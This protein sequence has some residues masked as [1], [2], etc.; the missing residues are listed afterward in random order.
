MTRHVVQSGWRRGRIES[1][2]RARLGLGALAL[3]EATVSAVERVVLESE[4][5][6]V[7]AWLSDLPADQREA[8]RRRVLDEAD[9]PTIASELECSEAVVRQ[10]VSRGLAALRKGLQ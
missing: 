2:A 4:E 5:A 9:Y 10:R 8:V 7:E 1:A 3:S 6:V